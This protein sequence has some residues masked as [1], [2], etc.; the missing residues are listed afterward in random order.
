MFKRK[1]KKYVPD[2]EVIDLLVSGAPWDNEKADRWRTSFTPEWRAAAKIIADRR[3]EWM[4][5]R[6]RFITPELMNEAR[7]RWSGDEV[8][9]P[10]QCEM[11]HGTTFEVEYDQIELSVLPGSAIWKQQPAMREIDQ[12]PFAIYTGEYVNTLTIFCNTCSF[13]TIRKAYSQDAE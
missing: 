10:D 13:R 6:N 7:Q 5:D 1:P 4:K 9:I 12:Y 11:C 3:D 2:Q 8:G